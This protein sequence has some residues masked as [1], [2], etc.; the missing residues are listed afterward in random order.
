MAARERRAG[1]LCGRRS[2]EAMIDIARNRAEFVNRTLFRAE[3]SPKSHDLARRQADE[4]GAGPG[5]IRDGLE[6][7]SARDRSSGGERD[8]RVMR[9]GADRRPALPGAHLR[10]FSS[11]GLSLA[12]RPPLECLT[13]ALPCARRRPRTAQSILRNI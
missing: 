5:P 1:R 11:E 6:Y 4:P 10:A 2:L 8:R 13:F 12:V 7:P 3:R 9:R